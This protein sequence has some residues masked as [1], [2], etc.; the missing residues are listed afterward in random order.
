MTKLTNERTNRIRPWHYHV[1]ERDLRYETGEP[2]EG[3]PLLIDQT[4]DLE[5]AM[6]NVP[7]DPWDA[8][9]VVIWDNWHGVWI[10][11]QDWADQWDFRAQGW[12]RTDLRPLI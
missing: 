4:D 2:D 5:I 3:E 1:Y 8:E 6:A 10:K 12:A 9:D 11:H 7:E